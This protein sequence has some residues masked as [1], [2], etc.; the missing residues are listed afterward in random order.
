MTLV[1]EVL[2][3]VDELILQAFVKYEAEAA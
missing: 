3:L 1:T 2:S